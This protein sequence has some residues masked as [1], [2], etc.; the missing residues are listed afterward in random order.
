MSGSIAW[1]LHNPAIHPCLAG[2]QQ[3]TSCVVSSLARKEVELHIYGPTFTAATMQPD[4]LPPRLPYALRP[5]RRG[6]EF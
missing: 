4:L 5:L 6:A 1:L 3:A 2:E